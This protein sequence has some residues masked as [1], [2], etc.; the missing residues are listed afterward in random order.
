[1]GVLIV[2]L[3]IIAS[4]G[5][6]IWNHRNAELAMAGVEFS[7]P[8]SAPQVAAAIRESYCG[9]AKA[10]IRSMAAGVKVAAS[11]P[12]SF[13]FETK[14]GDVGTI[15]IQAS[16]TS[17]SQ[18]AASAETLFVGNTVAL[19]SHRKSLYATGVALTHG[20]FVLLGLT[21]NAARVK[22]FQGGLERRVLK[23]LGTAA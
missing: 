19:R 23:R 12:T 1:M 18:V 2:V 9:G 5:G 21:P 8:W 6:V 11:G 16:G 17:G 13:R 22:R 20:I 3:L 14:A 7:V 4:I 15:T 10:T